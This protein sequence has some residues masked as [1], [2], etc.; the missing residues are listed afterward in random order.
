MSATL[1]EQIEM[2]LLGEPSLTAMDYK[3]R[4]FTRGEVTAFAK[5]LERLLLDG[6]VPKDATIGVVVRN[7]P[8]QAATVLGLITN[9]RPLTTLYAF[10]SPEAM[11]AD[12]RGSRFAAVIADAQ[13]WSGPVKEAAGSVGALGLLLDLDDAAGVSL[14]PGLA[15]FANGPYRKITGE[16][17]IEVLS[18]GTTGAPKRVLFPFRMLIRA[19]DSVKA[20]P[21]GTSLEPDIATWPLAGMGICWL[22]ADAVMGRHLTLLDKFNIP[23]WREA[24]LRHRPKTANGPPAILRMILDAKVPPEDLA[25]IEYFY[26]GSAPLAPELLE[27]FEKTYNITVVWAYGATEFC[28]TIISWTASLLEEFGQSK[29]GSMGR[30]LPGVTLRVTDVETGK[31]V[32]PGAVGYL[33]ALVPV[34]KPD[35]MRT[36]DL[37]TIDDDG[38]VFHRGR[39]DGA[40]V[41]GGFKVLP[42]SIVECL[43]RHPAVLDSGVIGLDDARLGQVPVAAVELRAGV[44]RPTEPEL[45]EHVRNQLPAHHVPTS[46]VIMEKLP[47]TASLKVSLA[48]L[49]RT[50]VEKHARLPDEGRL[51]GVEANSARDNV[52]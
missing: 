19:V 24:I 6:G 47:R 51:S 38:F 33:E 52:R 21:I 1:P 42:E 18:S 22:V 48:E 44:R 23:E 49:R 45:T 14:I 25:S 46:I 28:G 40:I 27:A 11:A 20:S 30:A 50:F 36:T 34:I 35:W 39:G 13:D 41:R 26:G 7:R 10:Q 9:G 2:A 32:A 16:P 43:N 5:R 4:Y 29:R 12:I 31:P 17:A 8:L 3:G 37:V 15:R